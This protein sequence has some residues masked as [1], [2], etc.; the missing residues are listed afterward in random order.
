MRKEWAVSCR[1]TCCSEDVDRDVICQ[2]SNSFYQN[3]T[4]QKSHPPH[5]TTTVFGTEQKAL[6]S[7]YFVIGLVVSL[8]GR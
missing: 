8:Y 7:N 1:G 3:S 6:S 4:L 2:V 5:N